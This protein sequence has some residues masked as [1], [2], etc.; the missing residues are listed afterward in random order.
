MPVG[1]LP[2]GIA[3]GT[4]R[5]AAVSAG[6]A[7]S[8]AGAVALLPCLATIPICGMTGPAGISD[9]AVCGTSTLP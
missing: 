2:A 4:L 5:A 8:E 6:V 7:A 9:A 3:A 1:A